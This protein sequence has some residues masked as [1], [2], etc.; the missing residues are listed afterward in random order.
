[1]IGGGGGNGRIYSVDSTLHQILEKS[2]DRYDALWVDFC[3]IVIKW[4]PFQVQFVEPLHVINFTRESS[5]VGIA[6]IKNLEFGTFTDL[7]RNVLDRIV[8]QK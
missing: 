1:M 4:T 8:V 3:K 2:H 6:Q 5:H 7:N